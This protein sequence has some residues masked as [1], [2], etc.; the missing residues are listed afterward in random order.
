M[1]KNIN[2]DSISK[3]FFALT[4]FSILISTAATN[5]FLILTIFFSILT[6]RNMQQIKDIFYNEIAISIIL[7]YIIFIISYTYT[8]ASDT[9][10]YDLLKKYFKFLYIPILFYIAKT[11][12]FRDIALKYLVFGSTIILILSYLKY[13][14]VLNPLAIANIVGFSYQEKLMEGVTVFQHSINHGIIL[15]FVGFISFILAKKGNN[16]FLYVISVCCFINTLLLNDSRSGYLISTV[17]I[18]IIFYQSFK[19]KKITIFTIFL[20]ITISSLA[21]LSSN[22]GKSRILIAIDNIIEIKNYNYDSSLGYRYIWFINGLN[23]FKENPIF[24]SGVGSYKKTIEEF[25]KDKKFSKEHSLRLV[26]QNPHNEFI[27]IVTQ[28]GSIGLAIFLFFLYIIIKKKY[29]YFNI[30][31]LST[32]LISSLFNSAFYDNILGIFCILIISLMNKQS[33]KKEN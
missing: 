5:I 23:N 3:L 31:I 26:T 7:L 1:I 19:H 13:F 12:D 14:N 2:L 21:V 22:V 8:I 18:T 33:Y 29:D 30:A 27:S 15:S 20:A 24:G 11:K 25:I 6:L 4:C 17:L 28:T 9:E 32:V 16:S 10:V